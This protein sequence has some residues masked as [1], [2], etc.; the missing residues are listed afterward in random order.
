MTITIEE[1]EAVDGGADP[2]TLPSPDHDQLVIEMKRNDKLP[3]EERVRL[4][5]QNRQRQ[6]ATYTKW[7]QGG[8]D[9]P[10]STGGGMLRLTFP[11]DIYLM[12]AA[13]KG[14]LAEMEQLLK[15]GDKFSKY[16]SQTLK[17]LVRFDIF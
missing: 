1:V 15:K 13:T 4:A 11:D 7:V 3:V 2:L 5:K 16:V 17:C 9:T 14:E 12:D 8:Q 10:P 6:L